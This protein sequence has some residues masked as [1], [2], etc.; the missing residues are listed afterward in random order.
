MKRSAPRAEKRKDSRKAVVE[1]IKRIE[2]AIIKGTEY[3][4]SGKHSDWKGF[5]PLFYSKTS[6]GKE[7]PPHRDWVKNFFLPR[8]KKAL[9]RSEK[10]LDKLS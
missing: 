3:L 2:D 4:E 7:L 6:D 10:L 5:R 9:S 1:R 8:M